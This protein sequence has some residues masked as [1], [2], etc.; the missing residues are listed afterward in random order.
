MEGFMGFLAKWE[1]VVEWVFNGDIMIEPTE[2][3]V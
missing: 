1:T 3:V 2:I